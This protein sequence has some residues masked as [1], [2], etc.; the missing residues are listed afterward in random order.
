[1]PNDKSHHKQLEKILGKLPKIVKSE[2]K[3]NL[4]R[5]NLLMDY[6]GH[7]ERSLRIIH[8]A[9]TS[10]K[11][12]TCYYITKL[13]SDKG[14][15]VGLS[16]SPYI[17]SVREVAQINLELPNQDK[18]ISKLKKFDELVKASGVKP[19]YY[20]FLTAFSYWYFDE[21][22][23]DYAVIEVG[24][25][26][27]LD[28][29][30]VARNEDKVCVIADIGFDHTEI[31]GHTIEEIT[32]QKAGIIHKSNQVFIND[33][34]YKNTGLI[35]DY[36]RRQN[37]HLHK[38]DYSRLKALG[39]PD[40]KAKNI[41]L[42]L[43]I[44]KFLN[45]DQDN[46]AIDNAEIQRLASLKIP[47]RQEVLQLKNK[48]IILDGAHNEQKFEAMISGLKTSFPET[49]FNALV[50]FGRNKQSYAKE[51]LQLLKPLLDNL[52]ITTFKNDLNE[53]RSS[54][55]TEELE[56]ICQELGYERVQAIESP[57]TALRALVN[58]DSKYILITGSNYL[59]RQIRATA[60]DVADKN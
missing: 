47:G 49:K 4:S 42:A 19:T 34:S 30:N 39:M 55:S 25:G 7:P 18:F 37:A 43:N 22:K 36:C 1:M 57:I 58:S 29:T 59:I 28:A 5:I 16:V 24:L 3:Y 13:L 46:Y 45:Q 10:G 38:L 53:E 56:G 6:L 17:E 11:T 33:V 8:I 14:L 32:L 60:I 35:E 52:T 31:L 50:T 2:E 9:G 44:C 48:T 20:E 12:S 51:C 26:G 27:L 41:N 40:F 23:V 54:M 15:K 21:E